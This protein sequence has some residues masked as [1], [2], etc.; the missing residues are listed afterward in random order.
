MNDACERY[1]E[2]PEAN[3]S[4]LDTC[5]ECRALFG[6]L[7]SPVPHR[8]IAVDALP[9][10]P[11]EGASHRAWPLVAVGALLLIGVATAAFIVSGISPR[12][13]I[14]Q[15]PSLDIL[16]TLVNGSG[17]FAQH[18][19]TAWQIGIGIAFVVVNMILVLLLRRSPRGVD[20]A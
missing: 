18:A 3:A 13:L 15:L 2:D 1:I 10:A 12:V 20:A 7:E 16:A 19:P 6:E 5:D 4:H 9:L 8:P 14:A 11:W 17:G